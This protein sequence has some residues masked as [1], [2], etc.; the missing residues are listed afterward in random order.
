MKKL[1]LTVSLFALVVAFAWPAAAKVECRYYAPSK[2]FKGGY[3]CYDYAADPAGK[4]QGARKTSPAEKT[5]AQKTPAGS[6]ISSLDLTISCAA[7][8]SAVDWINTASLNCGDGNRYDA[9]AVQKDRMTLGA[10]F[11]QVPPGR[12]CQVTVSSGFDSKVVGSV[13]TRGSKNQTLSGR[14]A[15]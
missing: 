5:T 11:R 10:Y 13:E 6:G 2:H 15:W 7:S 9:L 14:C 3:R 8:G 12:S 1:F 4:K